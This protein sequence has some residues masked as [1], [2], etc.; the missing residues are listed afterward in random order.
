MFETKI[1]ARVGK[2]I[3]LILVLTSFLS[4]SNLCV[5]FLN[6]PLPKYIFIERKLSHNIWIWF[7]G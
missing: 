7:L 4:P 1:V 5:D 3:K 6:V 2:I